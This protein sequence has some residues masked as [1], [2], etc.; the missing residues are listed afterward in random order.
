MQS[1]SAVLAG[2]A[3]A[4]TLLR[5][6][7]LRALYLVAI[8][9]G[10]VTFLIIILMNAS[11]GWWGLLLPL[12]LIVLFLCVAGVTAT[13]FVIDKITP[14]KLTPDER[15]QITSFVDDM[16]EKVVAGQIVRK[17]PIM[18]GV[19]TVFAFFRHGREG[20]AKSM[21]SPIEEIKDLK[22]RFGAIVSLF[23]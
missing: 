9:G 3:V 17:N 22:T 18:L 14:R 15:K 13:N 12:C 23:D 8:V 5:R 19:S 7:L 16:N 6:T 4:A 10:V 21:L 2:R 20:A 11:S 1:K